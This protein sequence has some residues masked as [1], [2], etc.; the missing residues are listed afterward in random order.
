[1]SKILSSKPLGSSDFGE[2][3]SVVIG[4]EL[5]GVEDNKQNNL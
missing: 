1:M 3:G 4:A 2:A 5:D